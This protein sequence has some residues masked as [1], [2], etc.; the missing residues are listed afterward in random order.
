MTWVREDWA[1]SNVSD[2]VKRHGK[3]KLKE[4]LGS[5]R[6]IQ[7]ASWRDSKWIWR[8]QKDCRLVEDDVW[9]ETFLVR[10]GAWNW[11]SWAKWNLHEEV[12]VILRDAWQ[13]SKEAWWGKEKQ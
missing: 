3:T 6:V 11:N 4:H 1:R 8:Q 2:K 10:R 5:R 13:S 12:E 9:R 7:E